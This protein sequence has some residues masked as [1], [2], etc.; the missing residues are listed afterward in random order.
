MYKPVRNG[1][2][3][4]QIVEQIEQQVVDGTLKA[5][6]RLPSER[7]LAK[8][9]GVS[10]TAVR[11][12]VKALLQRGLIEVNPGSG[13]F[14]TDGTSRALQHSLGLAMRLGQLENVASLIEL[15]EMMEP[16][17]AAKAAQ[18]ATQEHI[19]EL[20]RLVTIMDDVLTVPTDFI[21]ADFTFHMILAQA[22]QNALIPTIMN[23]VV[24]LLQEQRS[25]IFKADGGQIRAQIH[26]KR[27]L[28]AVKTKNSQAAFDAMV[29][30]LGQVREDFES[31]P[32]L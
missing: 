23:S 31:H 26:H 17:I 25:A 11:E 9:F 29:A 2:L 32:N 8:R 3:Y 18:R 16:A 6:D 19:V 21:S 20:E 24:D 28:Q 22:S 4:E 27:I 15:R 1:R 10:R 5:G 13:T 14:V 7:E 30:H 12:A